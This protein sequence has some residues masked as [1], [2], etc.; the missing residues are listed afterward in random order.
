MA[1]LRKEMAKEDAMAL[2]GSA[3]VDSEAKLTASAFILQGAELEA[4]Q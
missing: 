3:D 2:S 1:L 4:I